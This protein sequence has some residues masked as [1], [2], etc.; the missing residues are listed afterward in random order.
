MTGAALIAG[1]LI[2]A[3]ARPTPAPAP[4]GMRTDDWCPAPAGDP[5]GKH[6]DEKSCRADSACRGVPYLGES[7]VACIPDGRG[8]AEN[9][10]SVG[11]L[12]RADAAGRPPRAE[13][14]TRLCSSDLGGEGAEIRVWRT[15]AD[16]VA[17][18]ALHASPR[19]SHPPVVY[20]DFAGH[21]L[22]TVPLFPVQPGSDL[23]KEQGRQREAVVGGLHVTATLRCEK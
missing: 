13:V 4:C 7:V 11:C 8:F 16:A 9:C 15:A 23:A 14:V 20:H 21:R 18:L 12:S 6:K 2:L 1:A 19:L 22:L 3:A 10:P 17:V 5:C